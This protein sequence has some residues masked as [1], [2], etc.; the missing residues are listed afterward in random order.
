[1]PS[2]GY[3]VDL[4]SWVNPTG[5]FLP[6]SSFSILPFPDLHV[7]DRL[8]VHSPPLVYECLGFLFPLWRCSLGVGRVYQRHVR[9]VHFVCHPHG[10]KET[11]AQRAADIVLSIR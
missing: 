7:P 5:I 3:F 4:E 11:H 1:M 6:S 10:L 9:D 2:V 8:E